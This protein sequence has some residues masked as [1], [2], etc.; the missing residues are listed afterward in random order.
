M[1]Y[2]EKYKKA[3]ER[4]KKLHS[5]PTGG[6]ERI[7]CEQIFPELL[8]SEDER[9]RKEI[10]DFICWAIDRGSIT[11]EQ[12]EQSTSWISWLNKQGECK[13]N[14][15]SGTSFEYNGHTWGMCA[16]D[17]GVD[18]LLDCKP[19]YHFEEQGSQNLAN[20][21]KT[22]NNDE[23]IWSEKDEKMLNSIMEE[24]RPVGE[25]PDY[26]TSEEQEYYYK[27]QA[28]IDWLKSLKKR[29]GCEV[30]CTTKKNEK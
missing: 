3:L 16:R 18:I 23:E 21:A 8:E 14:P 7:V 1:N 11:K 17:Y 12:R 30:N 6:T 27:G 25:C 28:M 29:F 5:E 4:A 15:Y 13:P 20:S 22:C 2:E 19:I 26:P 10:R 24:I 9:M